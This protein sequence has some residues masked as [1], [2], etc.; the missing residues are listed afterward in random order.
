[1]F[2]QSLITDRGKSRLLADSKLIENFMQLHKLHTPIKEVSF[3]VTE[4]GDGEYGYYDARSCGFGIELPNISP[5]A[6]WENVLKMFDPFHGR[7]AAPLD[8]MEDLLYCELDHPIP[9]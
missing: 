9:E 5:W 1:M 6:A 4:S 7:M 2:K 3:T 8:E